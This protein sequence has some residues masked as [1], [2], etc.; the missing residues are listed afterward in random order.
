MSTATLRSLEEC[1]KILGIEG[2]EQLSIEL[3][4]TRYKERVFQVHTDTKD[5]NKDEPW[6]ACDIV[7]AKEQLIEMIQK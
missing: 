7:E 2:T 1:C 6:D 5:P 3:I 4:K